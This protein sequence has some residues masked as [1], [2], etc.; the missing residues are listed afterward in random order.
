MKRSIVSLVTVV[1]LCGLLSGTAVRISHSQNGAQVDA[2]GTTDTTPINQKRMEQVL[3]SMGFDPADWN[4]KRAWT[5]DLKMSHLHVQQFFK[6]VPVFGGEMIAHWDA[7]NA[8]TSI[9]NGW[10]RDL[11][12]NTQPLVTK[13]QA[14]QLAVNNY[15]CGKCFTADPTVKLWILRRDAR[16]RLVY[17]VRLRR[18]DGSAATAMPVYFID[19]HSGD[20]VWNYDDLQ[21]VA[22]SGQSLYDGVVSFESYFDPN[23]GKYFLEDL[24][25][26]HG[27]FDYRHSF[28]AN[29]FPITD[30][31]NL[32]T[33]RDPAAIEAQ[34]AA[35][36]VLDYYR[37][38]H[39]RNGLDGF[40]GPFAATAPDGATRLVASKVHYGTNYLNAYWDGASMTYGDGDGVNLSTPVTLDIAGHEMTHAVTYYAPRLTYDGEPGAL[41]ESM[42]DVFGAMIERH[43][44][45]LSS[46]TWKIGEDAYTP[47]TP[48]DAIRYLDNPHAVGMPADYREYVPNG[49]PHVNSGIP[50]LVFYLVVMGGTGPHGGEMVGI[51]PAQAEKIWYRALTTYM[52]S[53]TNFAAARTATL[54]AATDLYGQPAYDAVSHAWALCGVGEYGPP[55]VVSDAPFTN[56]GFENGLQPWILS[57]SAAKYATN[58]NAHG[59]A[60]FVR[61][62]RV[63]DE[64]GTLV[65]QFTYP[66]N[67][68]G[69]GLYFWLNVSTKEAAGSAQF[70]HLWVEI[71]DTNGQ[72]LGTLAH[73]SNADAT[74]VGN[75]LRRGPY[76]LDEFRGR[77]IRLEFRATSDHSY[78]TTFRID[79]VSI[80]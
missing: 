52:T 56:G 80:E 25:R 40:G 8:F 39:Q 63:N 17:S 41:N 69:I 71:R 21:T 3:Q 75:Y 1:T 50:S 62:G 26:R 33:K 64:T 48:G 70:D 11:R 31:D 68:N 34:Y 20:V 22:A 12:V 44:K 18:E 60:S 9:N 72:L 7:H 49:D 23:S 28:A 76:S 6:G 19:A 30:D 29:F 51:G 13:A 46:D 36:A 66:S 37:D 15:G 14:I 53:Q 2:T 61:L 65:Q 59:G 38:V 78:L 58:D 77:T 74:S 45:G 73:F 5:D 35:Q 42:S 79:D 32:W 55:V 54:A 16:D 67:L 57:P 43:V 47:S 4:V 10:V 27:T 24:T